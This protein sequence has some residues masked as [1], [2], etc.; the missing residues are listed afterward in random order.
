MWHLTRSTIL[1][2]TL[3]TLV[4]G[5]GGGLGDSS[6]D[7]NGS[8][9]NFTGDDPSAGRLLVATQCAQCH[10]TDGYSVTRIDSIAGES[11]SELMEE[12]VEDANEPGE[13][14]GFHGG[15]YLSLT[16]ELGAISG[17]LSQR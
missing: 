12:T 3:G 7:D 11:Y 16:P 17:Y 14:M 6:D 15:A 8:A 5:C 2:L 13:L 10:G 4:A 1:F 9:V